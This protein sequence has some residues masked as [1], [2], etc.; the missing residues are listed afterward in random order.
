MNGNPNRQTYIF[1][2]S[3]VCISFVVDSARE[4]FKLVASRTMVNVKIRLLSRGLAL[5]YLETLP[6]WA[7][8][9]R[10]RHG[11]RPGA[12]ERRGR[13]VGGRERRGRCVGGSEDGKDGGDA[14]EGRR[15]TKTGEM[16][17][18]CRGG[19]E[20]GKDEEDAEE[21]QRVRKTEEIRRR[22]VPKMTETRWEGVGGKKGL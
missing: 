5:K 8:L 14:S 9:E 18:R 22:T 10:V 12:W 15:T 20:D 4:S 11:G 19:S 1:S 21:G 6:G 17:R 16:R 7:Q 13:C 2:G 3:V